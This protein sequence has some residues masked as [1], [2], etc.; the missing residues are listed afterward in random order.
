VS[1]NGIQGP[2]DGWLVLIVAAL[3]LAWTRSMARASRVGIVAVLGAAAVMGWTAVQ[4]WLDGRDVFG[5]DVGWGLLL[6]LVASLVLAGTAVARA[7]LAVR[8][9]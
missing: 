5:A 8:E 4:D 6:V 3:A 9:R 2:N 7:V 1:L